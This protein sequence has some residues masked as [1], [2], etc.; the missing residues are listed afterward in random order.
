MAKLQGGVD[1]QL[2]RDLCAILGVD[3]NDVGKIVLT[4]ERDSVVADVTRF[5][6]S[7]RL[8]QLTERLR[9]VE[10]ERVPGD[11]GR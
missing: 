1:V 7:A 6:D 8:E 3:P 4:I 10:W 9:V 2:R 5:T 11:G